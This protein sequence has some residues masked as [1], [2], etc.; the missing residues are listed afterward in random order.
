MGVG[1]LGV[2]LGDG[3]MVGVGVDIGVDAVGVGD[4][5]R[6]GVGDARDGVDVGLVVG[7]SVTVACITLGATT[8]VVKTGARAGVT[9]DVANGVVFTICPNLSLS[10][11]CHT[12]TT[13]ARTV[14]TALMSATTR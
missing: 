6:E 9:I 7:A 3:V 11:G 1:S 10:H 12:A 13:T 8:V 2:G 4:G 5:V 14:N